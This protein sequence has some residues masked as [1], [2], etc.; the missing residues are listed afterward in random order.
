[1]HEI[2]IEED[3]APGSKMWNPVCLGFLAQPC[4]G[5]PMGGGNLG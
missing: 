1:M 3:P 2:W 4:A 5:N